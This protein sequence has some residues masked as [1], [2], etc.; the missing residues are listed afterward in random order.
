MGL[1]KKKESVPEVPKAPQLPEF[2]EPPKSSENNSKKDLPEL[3]SF[4]SN[5]SNENIN[6]QMVKS[7]VDDTHDSSVDQEVNKVEE[8]PRDFHFDIPEKYKKEIKKEQPIP[9]IPKHKMPRLPEIPAESPE[10]KKQ[11]SAPEK[12]PI[13]RNTDNTSTVGMT[14]SIRK[15]DKET[16]EKKSPQKINEPV[17]VRID[18]FQ[19]A[20]KHFEEIQK[21]VKEAESALSKIK[22]L[23]EKEE[24]E[25][26]EWSADLEKIKS[27]LSDI[28]TEIFTKL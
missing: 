8:L 11:I 12:K 27:R 5:N 3:P 25:I 4:P 14:P 1:F 23:K 18:K 21:K 9:E 2:P 15:Q 7:A 20:Q 22:D 19:K 17:F 24:K 28:D 10:D 6:Q 13:S 26:T 16:P